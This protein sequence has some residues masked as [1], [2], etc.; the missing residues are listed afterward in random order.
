MDGAVRFVVIEGLG[1]LPDEGCTLDEWLGLLSA[2]ANQTGRIA[3]HLQKHGEHSN[4][5]RFV[6]YRLRANI[7]RRQTGYQMKYG[8]VLSG[9]NDR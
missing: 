5:M 1:H 3:R 4:H 7:S 6:L 8:G 9:G 2:G